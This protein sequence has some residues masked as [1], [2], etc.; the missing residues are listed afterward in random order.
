MEGQVGPR[1]VPGRT[2]AGQDGL[3]RNQGGPRSGQHPGQAQGGARAGPG[4]A[5]CGTR[6][7]LGRASTHSSYMYMYISDNN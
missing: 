4:R 2:R 6:V 1:V 7:G 5:K 3:G